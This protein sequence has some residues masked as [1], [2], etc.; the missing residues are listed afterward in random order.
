MSFD[1]VTL[2]Y[3][4]DVP[5]LKF[6]AR[7]TRK[8]LHHESI[9]RILIIANDPDN[10]AVVRD[11]SETVMPEYGELAD[12]VHILTSDDFGMPGDM[13]KYLTQQMLKLYVAKR[14]ETETYLVLDA[15]NHF[16]RPLTFDDFVSAEGKPMTYLRAKY[17]HFLKRV[18]KSFECFGI[19]EPP[20]E[21]MPTTTP[22]V[23]LREATC[24]MID[25][26]DAR[27]PEGFVRYFERTHAWYTEFFLYQAYIV[28][29]YGSF[30]AVYVPKPN[31]CIT[32]FTNWPT[33]EQALKGEMRKVHW[34]ITYMF[35]IHAARIPELSTELRRQIIDMWETKKLIAPG[36]DI[37]WLMPPAKSP[38]N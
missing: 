3:S 35:G 9:N 14:V 33:D 13:D 19:D 2:V 5:L 34:K 23:M 4:K 30:Q 16:L 17:R 24:E 32:L 7:S 10:D 25:E 11:V 28:K 38:E 15:K 21:T 36:E 12:K 37:S 27:Q 6:Q 29:K 18:K 31:N 26:L 1:I 20:E 22:F 8:F